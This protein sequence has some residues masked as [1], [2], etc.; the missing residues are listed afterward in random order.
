M[1]GEQTKTIDYMDATQLTNL[2]KGMIEI[3]TGENKN[4]ENLE[5]VLE[6]LYAKLRLSEKKGNMLVYKKMEQILTTSHV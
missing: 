4:I 6:K 3:S 1:L 5:Q 2:L